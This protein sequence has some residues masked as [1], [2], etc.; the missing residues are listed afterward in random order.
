MKKHLLLLINVAILNLFVI[1]CS[2]D[3]PSNIN[4]QSETSDALY[5]KRS[6]ED[7]LKIANSYVNSING[8]KSRTNELQIDENSLTPVFK[9][10]SRQTSDTLI[11]AIDFKDNSGYMLISANQ[12]TEPIL[13]IIDEGSY[14]DTEGAYNTGYE[15][16]LAAAQNYVGNTYAPTGGFEPNP[17]VDPIRLWRYVDTLRVYQVPTK[18]LEVLWG[19]GWPENQYCPNNVAGC[20]PVATAQVLSYLKPFLNLNLTFE[21]KPQDYINIDWVNLCKHTNSLSSHTPSQSTIDAHYSGCGANE[22]THNMLALLVRQ[23]GEI[24]HALYYNTGSTGAFTNYAINYVKSITPDHEYIDVNGSNFYDY[25]SGGGVALVE[26]W[27]SNNVGHAWVID[28][29]YSFELY[30]TT[31]YNYCP[32][33]GEYD[34]KTV[35]REI[36]KYVHCNWGW[37]GYKNGYFLDGIYDTDS[38]I[39]VPTTPNNPRSRYNFNSGIWGTVF[40]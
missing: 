16:F 2:N 10:K 38:G 8:K 31:Y 28:G 23:L 20:V 5:L 26:G 4:P 34:S 1:S 33:T 6:K 24:T 19:Q 7:I 30:I 9:T 12:L 3:E 21:G 22:A 40:K 39:D 15:D 37:N 18:R 27:T 32:S 29:T 36:N 13:A 35:D 17:G 25:L 14:S 11:Y